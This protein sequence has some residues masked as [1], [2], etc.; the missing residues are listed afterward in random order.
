MFTLEDIRAQR[1]CAKGWKTLKLAWGDRPMD[2]ESSLGDVVLS[3]GLADALWCLR[4]VT[5]QQRVAAILPAVKRVS[6]FTTKTR[7]HACVFVFENFVA[8]G[9]AGGLA[10]ASHAARD[11]AYSAH[12]SHAAAYAAFA[13]VHASHAARTARAASRVA[14]AVSD[15]AHACHAAARAASAAADNADTAYAAERELQKA[16]LLAAFPPLVFTSN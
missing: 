13:A 6:A 7:V 16:D 5:R 10:H 9:N 14:R 4:L 11:A 8:T 1:P 3:N 12:A 15:A 2:F